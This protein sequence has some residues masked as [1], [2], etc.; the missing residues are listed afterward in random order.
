MRRVYTIEA[1]CLDCKLC[2]VYCKTQHSQSGDIIKA[3]RYEK[4]PEPQ[5]RIIV[6]GDNA[7][8]VAVQCRHC[9]EPKCVSACITGAMTQD[10]LTGVVTVDADRCI[11]CMTCMVACPFGAVRVAGVALKCDL[12][13]D[14]YGEPGEPVCV[15]ACPNQALVYIESE[16]V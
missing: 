3:W 4:D 15:A 13:G 7:Y 9:P 12:C 6:E 8:S 10:P 1:R 16:G 5:S 11:G 2:E 14:G